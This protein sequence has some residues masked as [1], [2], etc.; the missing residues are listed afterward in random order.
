MSSQTP[1]AEPGYR[2]QVFV[3]PGFAATEWS[4]AVD[5]IDVDV[6]VVGH[7]SLAQM[8]A[9]VRHGVP[10][11]V[12]VDDPLGAGD[13]RAAGVETMAYFYPL[14]LIA[15]GAGPLPDAC[16][17]FLTVARESMGLGE[18]RAALVAADLQVQALGRRLTQPLASELVAVRMA[19]IGRLA[20]GV[21]H[22]LNNPLAFSRNN[23]MLARERLS[24]AV[25]R[26]AA[27][28]WL[29]AGEDPG[30]V[31]SLVARLDALTS[32]ATD[33]QE[34]RDEL[35]TLAPE[36]QS[37]LFAEFVRYFEAS[38][39]AGVGPVLDALSSLDPLIRESIRGLGRM[40]EIVAGVRTLA[41]PQIPGESPVDIDR[42]VRETLAVL[43]DRAR[44]RQVTI[45]FKQRL[46]QAYPCDASQLAHVVL[47]VVSRALEAVS[48]ASEVRVETRE[49]SGQ[50]ELSVAMPAGADGFDDLLTGTLCHRLVRQ[51]GGVIVLEDN[52]KIC[53]RIPLARLTPAHAVER[54]RKSD[55][56]RADKS[57]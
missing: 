54:L 45:R 2:T 51:L 35:A 57:G 52:V 26:L 31:P 23:L 29:S 24:A 55:A 40:T 48:I 36:G 11:V 13:L 28:D 37:E 34:L 1:G 53:I 6:R 20:G 25:V 44:A 19:E 49:F 3:S 50:I 46:S 7:V 14:R 47:T 4:S 30:Q 9:P 27:K 22:E 39:V 41:R 32:H 12:V 18:F 17:P 8:L 16:T 33:V 10:A 38:E 56:D 15:I 42:T 43:R 21:I 5:D